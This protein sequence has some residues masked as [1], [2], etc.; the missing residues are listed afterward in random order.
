[1]IGGP[2]KGGPPIFFRNAL[3]Q[4]SRSF[5]EAL[6]L[7][8]FKKRGKKPYSGVDRESYWWKNARS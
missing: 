7:S 1:M 8:S 5:D 2:P 4:P 6:I 3:R